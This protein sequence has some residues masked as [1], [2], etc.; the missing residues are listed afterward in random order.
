MKID[1]S[2]A[3]RIDILPEFW[4]LFPALSIG[5]IAAQV[6]VLPSDAGLRDAMDVVCKRLQDELTPELIRRHPVVETTK[7]AY[8]KMGQDPNRYRPSAESLM[9]RIALGKGLYFVNNMVDI[10]NIISVE[11]GFSIGG[12]DADKIRGSISFGKGRAD[13]PYVGIGRGELKI[14]NLPVFRDLDGAF[15]T[16]TSDSMRTMVDENTESFLMLF[17]AFEN[18]GS[19]LEEALE[20]S[21]KLLLEYGDV[22]DLKVYIQN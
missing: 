17:P 2:K 3:L 1:N 22:R 10:L 15:G 13:E 21:R 8:R 16:S 4:Q 14:K 12:Y 20:L 19:R 5:S 11:S 7:N 6:K 9:R 18:V